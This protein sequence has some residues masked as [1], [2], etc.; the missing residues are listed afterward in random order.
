MNLVK[1]V[2]YKNLVMKK[3][4]QFVWIFLLVLGNV[5][6]QQEKGITG[7]ENWLRN[8]TEFKPSQVEYGEPTQILTGNISVDTK[9]KK[10]DVYL[11]LGS[12]F[13]TNRA[14]LTVEP[15]TLIIGDYKTKGSLT[16]SRGS[17]IIA[18]GVR[19][20]PIIF[21]SNRSVKRPGDWGGLIILGEAPINRFGSGSAASYYPKLYGADYANTNYGGE[22][23]DCSSGILEFVRIE[24]A[25]KRI[26]SDMYFSGLLL[27]SVGKE[28]TIKNVMVSYSAGD[29][30]TIWGGQVNLSRVVSYKSNGNDFK[31]NYGSQSVISNSLAVRSPYVSNPKGSRCLEVV[32][33][34]TKEE[35][36]FSKNS[37]YVTANNLT[38][39][40]D[41]DNLASDIKMNL[42]KSAIYVGHS[43][44]FVMDKS[45]VSGFNPAVILDN[46][47][48][49]NQNAL[50]NIAFTDMYFNNCNGN[51]FIENNSNNEDLEN[52][53]G[54]AAFFNVYSKSENSETFI[55]FKNDKRP[56]YRLRIN[57][58]I[59]SNEVEPD[60]RSD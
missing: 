12:V 9:L 47:I 33:Y 15:G 51:I 36:D 39:L 11:L 8:W 49:I 3:I 20:D 23:L 50:E 38:L 45:V 10:G 21:T 42:V 6:S 41:S 22:L 25:G 26:T 52:W 54:N 56:D 60:L 24:Y 5:Y 57:K 40:N 19:T 32:S 14:T 28:T 13:V 30:Y 18:K 1:A 4:T 17:K 46:N 29:S 58:I 31:F 27:A 48:T 53:Y 7:N 2:N 55:D 16:I 59:A 44:K 37:T 43:S 35:F 34:D